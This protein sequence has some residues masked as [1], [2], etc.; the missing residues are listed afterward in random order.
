MGTFAPP[1]PDDVESS[2]STFVPPAPT[3]VAGFVPPS[4]TEV[5]A[6]ATFSRAGSDED[7]GF[8]STNPDQDRMNQKYAKL[9]D[10]ILAQDAPLANSDL[11]WQQL[12][13]VVDSKNQAPLPAS[14][15]AGQAWDAVWSAPKSLQD[16]VDLGRG[17]Q[18]NNRATTLAMRALAAKHG[19]NPDTVAKLPPVWEQWLQGAGNEVVDLA[20]GLTSPGNVATLGTAALPKAVQRAAALGFSAQML[21]AAPQ[22]A[23]ALADEMAKSEGERDNAKIAQNFLGTLVNTG[24]GVKAAEHGVTPEA[25]AA[26][27]GPLPDTI[28]PLVDSSVPTDRTEPVQTFVP[29]K[30]D[31]VQQAEP[32]PQGENTFVP[33]AP[34]DTLTQAQIDS[35]ANVQAMAE[36]RA[37]KAARDEA[38]PTE[39]AIPLGLNRPSRMDPSLADLTDDQ[40]RQVYSSAQD[41]VDTAEKMIDQKG[42]DDLTPQERQTIGQ[43]QDQWTAADLEQFRRNTI[44]TVP[45][46]LMHQLKDIAPKAVRFGQDSDDFQKAKII[47]G[48]LQRQ[49][50]TREEMLSETTL[51]SSDKAEVFK[52]DMQDVKKVMDMMQSEKVASLKAATTAPPSPSPRT[53]LADRLVPVE[54]SP[55]E[56]SQARVG[57]KPGTSVAIARGLAEETKRTQLFSD[58]LNTERPDETEAMPAKLLYVGDQ[59]KL[60]GQPVRVT[61]L[62]TDPETGEPDHVKVAGAYGEQIIPADTT[63]NLDKDTL[64]SPAL[65]PKLAGFGGSVSQRLAAAKAAAR[66]KVTGGPR[67]GPQAVPVPPAVAGTPA[68]P[69][70]PIRIWLTGAVRGVQN[71]FAPHTIDDG[72]ATTANI[73]RDVNGEKANNL[74]QADEAM[75]TWRKE[76]DRT[77]VPANYQYDAAKPLP[78]NYAVIDAMERDRSKLDPRYQPLAQYF[79]TAFQN[80]IQDIQRYAPEALQKLITNYF[81][82]IWKDPDRAAGVMQQ[83]ATGLFSGRKE[84]LKQRSL[85]FF[86]DGLERGLQPISD[87]P[88]DLLL[89]KM[90]SMDKMIAALK[91]QAQFKSRGLMKFK[92][93]LETMPEGFQ[94]VDDPAFTIHAPPQVTVREAYDAQMRAKLGEMLRYL[95][96][97][98]TRVARLGGNRWGEAE[99]GLGGRE[100][101]AKLGASEDVLW[102]E[103]GHHID[104][105]FP[106]LRKMFDM[107]GN[108]IEAQQLRR[109][110][111]LNHPGVP[112]N[113]ALGYHRYLRQTEEKMAEV[114]RAYVK[115]PQFLRL[116]ASEIF[117]KLNQWLDT[118][119]DIRAHL[120]A[121]KPGLEI[122]HEDT[123]LKLGGVLKLGDWVMPEGAAQV[124]KNHLSPGL[125]RSGLYRSVRAASNLMNAAQLGLSGFHVGFTSLD[126]AISTVATGLY[127]ATHGKP[128]RGAATIAKS[129]L[130][131]LAN[132]FTGKAVQR[133]M[134]DPGAKTFRGMGMNMDITPENQKI[135]DLAVKGGLRATVDPFWQTHVTRNLMRS[136][137]EGGLAWGKVPLQAPFALVEQ[138]M[139]PIAEYLVPR[140][141]LGVFALMAKREMERLP[142]NA[143]PDE[144]RAAM[145]RAADATEDRMG[146]MT[147]DNL[148]YNKVAKDLSLLAFRAYGWQLGKY[149]H[150]FGAAA[151]TI[152]NAKQIGQ[153]KLPD[154]TQRQLYFIALPLVVAAI[155]ATLNKIFTGKNPE[156]L[157]DYF[158]PQTGQLDAGGNPKR[159]SLPTYMKDLEADAL[160]VTKGYKQGGVVGAGTGVWTATYHRLN[161]AISLLADMANNRDFYGTQIWTPDDTHLQQ[162]GEQAKF[163]GKSFVPF[164]I[165]GAQKLSQGQSSLKDKVL[166]F[167]GVVPASRIL[168]MTPTESYYADAFRDQ[169]P[170]GAKTA[171]QSEVSQLRAQLVTDLKTAKSSGQAVPDLQARMLAAGIKDRQSLTR[172]AEKAEWLP[173]QYQANYLPLTTAMRGFDLASDQEK[174]ELAPILLPRVQN[175][176]DRDEIDQPTTSRY[177]KLLAAARK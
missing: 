52:A 151:D 112:H 175:A 137:R 145:A 80:R 10:A 141:K 15:T 79:D 42:I 88:V 16:I 99:Q 6:P 96:V 12:M 143:G 139:R 76:F 148:F 85:P 27:E 75:H 152:G 22:Q 39:E 50:A 71:V 26:T 171:Q 57:L 17:I 63:V 102:H 106:E 169:M 29:P 7:G 59:F 150:L 167:F 125:S 46:D 36:L 140:Q 134:L 14:G 62:V 69:M 164:S 138:A 130:A 114:F 44:D 142:A 82:H 176:W 115:D 122:G 31:E 113:P 64:A 135:A 11:Q 132:Y 38:A 84:F 1:A 61:D 111:D 153:G 83:V 123:T 160:G 18:E 65:E 172:L 121:I 109:L 162:L 49:S 48:E 126:A 55:E 91:A 73:L 92:Y 127:D 157:A 103:L 117:R 119:P 13:K 9:G 120:D 93:A 107:R 40:F 53:T 67:P 149:R 23:Q 158:H 2:G 98:L 35:R 165:S 95:G 24:L 51:N 21:A 34:E 129:L 41:R 70:G 108:S 161:P 47:I 56:Y 74:A 159:L 90:H 101:R 3:E 118:R 174:A 68:P 144:L 58:T 155:G 30:P 87:N 133:A 5:Q 131:P 170:G 43:T 94:A 116:K 19:I 128:G 105:Q 147:Y 89:A 28:N 4:P 77:P 33:P 124:M 156:T 45:Q 104:W 168:T 60:N 20:T 25:P 8:G 32:A 110:V 154:L 100:I 166:P 97:N 86:S 81:P 136:V 37:Q 173:I 72:A 177:V 163:I 146:Q 66:A 78:H 54:I